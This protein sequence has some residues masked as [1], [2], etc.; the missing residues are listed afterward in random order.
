MRKIHRSYFRL[1]PVIFLV[2]GISVT[3]ILTYTAYRYYHELNEESVKRICQNFEGKIQL[4]IMA[5]AQNLYSSAAF[6]S[7]SDSV[8]REEWHEF[9]YLNK[10]YKELSGIGGIG[11]MKIV[12]RG[13]LY[14]FEKQIQKEGFSGFRVR[15]EGNREIYTPVLYIEP[16]SGLNL[17]SL[18]F[19]A[20]TEPV[21]QK[22]MTDSREKNLAI[23]SRGFSHT[24]DSS[25][26]QISSV[27]MFVPVYRKE[28]VKVE[29]IQKR[30][31]I[32]G[33]VYSPLNIEELFRDI[34]GE[35]DHFSIRVQI[36]DGAENVPGRLM[37]D[38]DSVYRVN[39][40]SAA[41][42]EYSLDFHF[43]T[44]LWTLHFSSYSNNSE[45]FLGKKIPLYLG[46]IFISLLLLVLSINLVISR[47]RSRKI[48]LLNDSLKKANAEKDRFLSLVAHDL[49]SPFHL[50]LGFSEL[51][52]D[53][54]DFLTE[55]KKKLYASKIHQMAIVTYSLLEELLM[56]A[57]I[58][59]GQLPFQPDNLLLN[60]I[61]G[62]IVSD[63]YLMAKEKKISIHCNEIENIEVFADGNML[64]TIIRNLL[65][66]AIKFTHEGGNV[67][68]DFINEKQWV[69]VSV[70]DT[71]IG[72]SPDVQSKLFNE[73]VIQTTEGTNDEKG[74]GLGLLLCKELVEKHGGRIW[75]E[76]VEGK[77]SNFSFTMPLVK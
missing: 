45:L 38:S 44:S 2:I 56:W 12:P 31:A 74:T 41:H 5:N 68:I 10:S 19:D 75:F 4:Q 69:T 51:L 25:L 43:N 16:F 18:G 76:S 3:S 72:L 73:S 13:Q 21:L 65:T 7:G 32:V 35:W 54:F 20:F 28:T 77:G 49:K 67:F 61:C 57:K 15:P 66:N 33:W 36:Y 6:I 40:S 14:L 1:I 55:E 46:G 62:S 37:F 42:M 63:Y 39:R 24:L 70:I 48:Q 58:Q 27:Y 53:N 11:F 30:N 60:K 17:Q 50:F 22:A 47:A 9:Q 34:L 71:G 26:N 29:G 23:L 8:T 59:S 64:R 52:D